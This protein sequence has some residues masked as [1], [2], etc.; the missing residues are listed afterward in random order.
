MSRKN[1][2]KPKQLAHPSEN[3]IPKAAPFKTDHCLP[4]FKAGQMDM[5]GPWGWN[6]F[7]PEQIQ[8]VFQK[9]FDSQKLTW[10]IL[11]ENGSHFVQVSSLSAEA[12]KRLTELQKDE[13]EELFS[14]RLTGRIRIWGIK[15]GNILW[16][17]WWDPNHGVCPS[18]KKHT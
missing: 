7:D 5:D 14:L 9:I 17:L 6:K 11:R 13:W 1:L 12:Q 3:K 18:N 10:Q 2:K 15:D 4:E 8:E 16:L